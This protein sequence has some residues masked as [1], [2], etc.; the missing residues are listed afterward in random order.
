MGERADLATW[1]V[2]GACGHAGERVQ[3]AEGPVWEEL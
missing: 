2:Q 1:S 3:G